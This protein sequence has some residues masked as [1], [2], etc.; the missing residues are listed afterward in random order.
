MDACAEAR[1]G[2]D[3]AAMVVWITLVACG[4]SGSSS[5]SSG[6]S[7][8]AGG[9]GT[10]ATAGNG[11]TD[12]SPVVFVVSVGI[13]PGTE[14]T[15]S[16]ISAYDAR[17]EAPAGG[18]F[19]FS[20]TPSG[21]FSPTFVAT[22]A[23]GMG[24]YAAGS[25][26]ASQGLL[27]SD[28]T[29][30]QGAEG[31]SVQVADARSVSTPPVVTSHGTVYLGATRA[32]ETAAIFVVPAGGGSLQA[33]I[34]LDPTVAFVYGLA[35]DDA[36]Q[37]LYALTQSASGQESVEIVDEVSNVVVGSIGAATLAAGGATTQHI[38]GLALSPDGALAYAVDEGSSASALVTFD[39]AAASASEKPLPAAVPRSPQCV[40][41][42]PDGHH[43]YVALQPDA[44][45]GGIGAFDTASGAT[46]VTPITNSDMSATPSVSGM[47]AIDPA[48]GKVFVAEVTDPSRA[49]GDLLHLSVFDTA[50]ATFSNRVVVPRFHSVDGGPGALPSSI[51]SLAAQ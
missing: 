22:G 30:P 21:P 42:S 34:A 3:L 17:T 35:S 47:V 33:T 26:G 2:R 25:L 45:A 1:F 12:R 24:L 5:T 6:S 15:E 46:S 37:K 31:T 41:A 32:D 50:S 36:A 7:S 39:L 28:I 9:S 20:A 14:T 49:N 44:G 8:G 18:V 40:V 23:S 38:F 4:G 19:F 10:G 13:V 16:Q 11:I 51:T 29:L 48:G 43:V 27:L